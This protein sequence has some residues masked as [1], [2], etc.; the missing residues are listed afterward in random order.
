MTRR[1]R[2]PKVGSVMTEFAGPSAG[3]GGITFVSVP[4][5]ALYVEGAVSAQSEEQRPLQ[6]K[7]IAAI[8]HI[9]FFNIFFMGIE[10]LRPC[11]RGFNVSL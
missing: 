9:S 8:T 1:I 4:E 11:E 2:E 10:L 6:R 3:A 7:N 5:Y